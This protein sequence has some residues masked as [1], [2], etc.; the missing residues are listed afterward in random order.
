MQELISIIIVLVIVFIVYL[1]I[2]E[3][4]CWYWKVNERN[5]KLDS[6][7]RYLEKLVEIEKQRE[8]GAKTSST[9]NT[10]HNESDEVE[11][12]ICLKINYPNG[13]VYDGQVYEGIPNGKGK[14]RDSNG[15]V[16]EGNF[17]AGHPNGTGT[18]VTA[19]G[20]KFKACYNH[21]KLVDKEPI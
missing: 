3:L 17:I 21:G 12:K 6:I 15:N 11:D 10:V 18:L 8:L 4:N 7:C 9:I 14:M 2:R 5:E 13:E 20:N 16:F 19:E 1:L